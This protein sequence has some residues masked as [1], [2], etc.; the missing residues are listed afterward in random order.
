MSNTY[1]FR[2]IYMPYCLDRLEDGR[3]VVLNR[4]YKP[5]GQ[6]SREQVDYKDFAVNL[7][8]TKSMA[9]RLSVNGDENMDR[10]YLYIEHEH[11]ESDDQYW[12][13]YSDKLKLLAALLTNI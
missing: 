1:N 4:N 3:Y 13:S 11:P 7:K 6:N 8:I 5:L 2:A 12:N 9:K 10:V